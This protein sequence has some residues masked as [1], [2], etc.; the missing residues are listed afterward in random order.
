[1]GNDIH[2]VSMNKFA[3]YLKT[4]EVIHG[5]VKTSLI[6]KTDEGSFGSLYREWTQKGLVGAWQRTQKTLVIAN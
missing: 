2:D 6:Q 4:G 5:S 3:A 1:M